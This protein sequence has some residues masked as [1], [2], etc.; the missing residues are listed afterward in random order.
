MISYI[1]VNFLSVLL[2]CLYDEI[3]MYVCTRQKHNNAG[4]SE[5]YS[6]KCITFFQ[7]V[8]LFCIFIITRAKSLTFISIYADLCICIVLFVQIAVI[9]KNVERTVSHDLWFAFAVFFDD[10]E[11]A[12][13]V[14]NSPDPRTQ[15]SLAKSIK[16]FNESLWNEQSRAV[17]KRGSM[18]KVWP[19]APCHFFHSV[20]R[21]VVI[22]FVEHKPGN[23]FSW[24]LLL[25]AVQKLSTFAFDVIDLSFGSELT[26]WSSL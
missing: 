26:V 10:L 18:E 24:C 17:V 9:C 11:V 7:Q 15:K 14:L 5:F 3:K 25:L 21:Y 16:N 20:T 8:S 6:L 2:C 13:E 1:C 19:F 23:F 4:F 12:T 22:V